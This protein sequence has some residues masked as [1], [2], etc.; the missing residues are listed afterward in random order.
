MPRLD[1]LPLRT[2]EPNVRAVFDD[3]MRERG[4]VPN[5]F[6]TYARRLEMMTTSFE[7]FR[8]VMY[9]G[10]VPVTEK[11]I[12][13]VRTSQINGCRYCL[14]SHLAL[15]KKFGMS[16]DKLDRLGLSEADPDTTSSIGSGAP[17]IESVLYG[18]HDVVWNSRERI[19]L[20][21]ADT[22]TRTASVSDAIWDDACTVFQPEELMEIVAVVCLFNYYNR[23]A[24]ALEIE[25]TK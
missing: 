7:H 10:S 13:A 15:A 20:K 1:P 4:N 25:I 5:L 22:L 11:E 16:K 12:A 8:K 14:A 2:D 24:N 6:R 18:E 9:T 23:F 17:S 21:L 3:F 19:I